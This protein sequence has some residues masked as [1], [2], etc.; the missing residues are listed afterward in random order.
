MLCSV[1]AS[2][3]VHSVSMSTRSCTRRQETCSKDCSVEH[4]H[5]QDAVQ[6]RVQRVDAEFFR[7]ILYR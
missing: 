3:S 2:A 6:R 7:C 5:E 1:W 4:A